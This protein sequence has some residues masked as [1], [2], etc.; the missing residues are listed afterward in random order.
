NDAS[1]LTCVRGR[2]FAS[3]AILKRPGLRPLFDAVLT[4]GENFSQ[5]PCTA[6]TEVSFTRKNERPSAAFLNQASASV[7]FVNRKTGEKPNASPVD[8]LRTTV[9]DAVR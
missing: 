7:Q 5:R 8:P 9:S 1:M 4:C 3:H 2:R 6:S